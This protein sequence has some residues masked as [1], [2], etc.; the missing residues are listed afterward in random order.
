MYGGRY[1]AQQSL[2]MRVIDNTYTTKDELYTQIQAFAKEYAPKGEHRR[3]LKDMKHNVHATLHER[4]V[5]GGM[6][7]LEVADAKPFDLSILKGKL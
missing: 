5:N 1:N 7:L 3:A 2:K 4:L 6:T